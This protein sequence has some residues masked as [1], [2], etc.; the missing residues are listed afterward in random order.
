MKAV[1]Y[2]MVIMALL[3][4]VPASGAPDA[5]PAATQPAA[6]TAPATSTPAPAAP[7]AVG[8]R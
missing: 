4:T 5:Q 3:F 6:V 1:K 2:T 7:V 8:D